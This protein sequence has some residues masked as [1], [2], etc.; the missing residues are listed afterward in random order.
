MKEMGVDVAPKQLE[1]LYLTLEHEIKALERTLLFE[2]LNIRVW[3]YLGKCYYYRFSFRRL[4]E[5]ILN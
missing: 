4:I 3:Y 5:L 2:P 1:E